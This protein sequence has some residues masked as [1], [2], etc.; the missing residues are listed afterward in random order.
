MRVRYL[1]KAIELAVDAHRGQYRKGDNLPFIIHP[2]DVLNRVIG[3]GV[4]SDS[5]HC[6]VV[7]HDT[8]ED[9]WITHEYLATIFNKKVCMYV[10]QLTDTTDRDKDS[11]EKYQYLQSFANKA[12]TARV[13]K[14]ADRACAVKDW[15]LTNQKHFAGK[16]ALMAAPLIAAV[17]DCWDV[18]PKKVQRGLEEDIEFIQNIAWERYPA[19]DIN[20]PEDLH[21]VEEVIKNKRKEV[22]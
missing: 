16:Y 1:D 12:P 11:W 15:L 10:H 17:R 22:K 6:G 7:L 5:A 3:Y 9:T 19:I 14:I 13:I 21:K 2:M 18:I 20:N 4:E 8:V